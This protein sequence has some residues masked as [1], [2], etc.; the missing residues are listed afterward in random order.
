MELTLENYEIDK[1]GDSYDYDMI[2]INLPASDLM[3]PPTAPAILKGIAQSHGFKVLTHDFNVDIHK[4]FCESKS[5]KYQDLQNYWIA[6]GPH[7]QELHNHVKQIYDYIIDW[8]AQYSTK[9]IGISVFSVWTHIATWEFCNRVKERYPNWKIVLGGKGLTTGPYINF[10]SKLTKIEKLMQFHEI[11]MKKKLVYHTILGDAED[12]LLEF[13][14][15]KLYSPDFWNTTSNITLSYPF[16]NFDDYDFDNYK[17]IASRLMIPVISSKG[18]VRSCDFC[19]VSSN[20]SKFQSKN[21]TRLAEEIIYLSQKYNRNEFV[22]S[23]SIANGNMKALSECLIEIAKY[24]DSLT[25]N[26]IKISGNWISRPPNSIKPEFFNLMI[27]AGFNHV[28]IGAE[29]GSDKVLKAMDKK[30]TVD[31]LFYELNHMRDVGIGAIINNIVGHCLKSFQ[32]FFY[33]LI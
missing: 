22:L 19:D 11:I 18:C 31:G 30:T 10:W 24:N 27:K 33:I 13:L 23:D 28:T 7:S 20:F 32:I 3:V 26:K 1:T 4:I 17:G 6:E 8:L 12:S 16:S 25:D 15:G 5:E 14:N 9:F 21:G 2:L 29:S